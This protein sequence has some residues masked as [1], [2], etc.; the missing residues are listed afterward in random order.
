MIIMADEDS[1]SRMLGVPAAQIPE[2]V[3][4]EYQLRLRMFHCDG[5]A[6]PLGTIGIIDM[7]RS[8]KLG[9]R[10]PGPQPTSIDWSRVPMNG[11]VRVM[12]KVTGN[13]GEPKWASGVYVGQV[14]VGALAVRL[15]GDRWV[16]E[17]RRDDVRIA[18]DEPMQ[19]MSP[20]DAF[21]SDVPLEDREPWVSIPLGEQVLVKDEGVHKEGRFQGVQGDE[22]LV[23]VADDLTPRPFAPEKV[24]CFETRLKAK[25]EKRGEHAE[26]VHGDDHD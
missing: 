17:M 11:S 24:T 3:L 20:E 26:P 19:P 25:A 1:L 4:A 7:L 16:H 23:L 10:P 8:M 12:A 18:R 6:G 22:I 15:D 9:M 2:S 21:E 13:N 14:G 5:N